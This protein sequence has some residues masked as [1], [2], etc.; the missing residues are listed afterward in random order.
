M[1]EMR[2]IKSSNF[3]IHM[4][5]LSILSRECWKVSENDKF[6]YINCSMSNVNISTATSMNI[7]H[8]SKI[9][10]SIIFSGETFISIWN[11]Q[12]TKKKL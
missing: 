6:P 4:L 9:L 3:I 8:S 10:F 2:I 5:L 11:N 1:I 7:F 12:T